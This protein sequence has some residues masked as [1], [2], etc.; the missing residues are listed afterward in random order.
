MTTSSK[1]SALTRAFVGQA[2]AHLQ[3]DFLPKI[4][5]CLEILSDDDVWWRAS[6]ANHKKKSAT[7][8]TK[9][10][11]CLLLISCHSCNSWQI[12]FVSDGCQ[13]DLKE[14]NSEMFS[15]SSCGKVLSR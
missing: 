15:R 7:N 1:S 4:H 5:K 3:D 6:S 10:S 12:Y 14:K 13:R 2:I 9:K 8:Y 11:V